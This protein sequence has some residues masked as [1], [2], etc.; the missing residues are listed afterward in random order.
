VT[1]RD[2]EDALRARI[3]A[4][5]SRLGQRSREQAELRDELAR[6]RQDLAA[7]HPVE[8]E[9]PT[10]LLILGVVG[11]GLAIAGMVLNHVLV[12]LVG[13]HGW[14]FQSLSAAADVGLSLGLI[15]LYRVTNQRLAL[16]AAI[17][18]LVS[19]ALHLLSLLAR[20]AGAGQYAMTPGWLLYLA[21]GVVLGVAL[22]RAPDEHLRAWKRNLAGVLALVGVLF[23]TLFFVISVFLVPQM[24]AAD[25]GQLFQYISVPAGLVSLGKHTGLLLCFLEL[26]RP[27]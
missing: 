12:P 27:R 26:R 25:V 19:L 17:M 20:D 3:Q 14:L 24:A 9:R 11:C 1:Y 6:A 21:T 15:G 18:V 13:Y 16:A 22:L 23:S 2:T 10:A 5:E 8:Q 7:L 4:L